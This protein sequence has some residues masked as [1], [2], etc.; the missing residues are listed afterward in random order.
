LKKATESGFCYSA[1]AGAS[2]AALQSGF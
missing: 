1:G 2:M